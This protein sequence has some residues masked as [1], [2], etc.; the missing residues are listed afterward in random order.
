VFAIVWD[1][2]KTWHKK[3]SLKVSR[4]Y[5]KSILVIEF[6]AEVELDRIFASLFQ[7]Y[8]CFYSTASDTTQI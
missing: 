8:P 7:V 1:N 3:F 2:H 6:L 4:P 5:S